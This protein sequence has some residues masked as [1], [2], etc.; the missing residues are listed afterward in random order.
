MSLI[1]LA[2]EAANKRD[3][4]LA[5][6]N[7]ADIQYDLDLQSR[8]AKLRDVVSAE[9]L[10]M[11]REMSKF[12]RLLVS[13]GHE[14]RFATVGQT[15]MTVT[16]PSSDENK[17]V[18]ELSLGIDVGEHKYSDESD[19]VKYRDPNSMGKDVLT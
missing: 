4:E 2:R 18:L 10:Q 14:I 17:V 16:I 13:G 1:S 3:L 11:D 7:K 8:L 6:K 5:E 15:F 19:P 12:G 9:I